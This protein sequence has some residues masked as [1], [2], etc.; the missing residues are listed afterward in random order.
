MLK[1]VSL[2]NQSAYRAHETPARPALVSLHKILHLC[3][4]NKS[5]TAAPIVRA[6]VPA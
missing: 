5:E 4:P 1:A 3:R 6:A 2:S